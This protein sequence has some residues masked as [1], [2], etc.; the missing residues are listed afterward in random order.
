MKKFG[1]MFL[2][3][4]AFALAIPAVNAQNGE[5]DYQYILNGMNKIHVSVGEL[6]DLGFT[7]EQ[8]R[9]QVQSK[10]NEAG[11]KVIGDKEFLNYTDVNNFTVNVKPLKH[12]GKLFYSIKIALTEMVYLKEK[13]DHEVS[14]IVWQDETVGVNGLKEKSKLKSKILER[15]DSFVSLWKRSNGQSAR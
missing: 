8:I 1:T 7:R 13:T 12:N 3:V 10:L 11:L 6:K 15:V 2:M 5:P 14:V 4:I 9:T